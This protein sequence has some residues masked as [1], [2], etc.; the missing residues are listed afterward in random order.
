M[1]RKELLEGLS[2]E[3]IEMVEKCKSQDEL[4]ALAKSE[5][6]QLTDEQL[7]AV[8]GGCDSDEEDK[9]TDNGGKNDK[10]DHNPNI[11]PF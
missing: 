11:N 10:D 6:V 5:G 2:E 9:D 7:A 8:S 3:Q 1:N 4:M